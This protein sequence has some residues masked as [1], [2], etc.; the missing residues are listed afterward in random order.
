MTI[1]RRTSTWLRCAVACAV[2]AFAGAPSVFTQQAA[3]GA[4]PPAGLQNALVRGAQAMRSGDTATA[5]AAFREAVRLGPRFPDAHLDLGLVL[6]R[7]GR[8]EES[9][10]ELRRA[11]A[12]DPKLA[13]AH[14]FLGIFLYQANQAEPARRELQVELSLDPKSVEALTW[15]GTIDLAENHPERAVVSL[16]RA[17]EF[18]PDDLNI[19]ELRGRAHNQVAHDSYARM[20]RLAPNSWH[21][22]RVQAGLYSDEGRHTEA[23]AEYKAAIEAEGRNPDLYEGLGDEYR[24][25]SQLEDA[26]AAYAREVELS[27]NNPIALY[28]LG[29]TEIEQGQPE[30][31]VPRLQRMLQMAK[32]FPVAEYYLGR[33]LAAEGQD[34]EAVTWLTKAAA[35]A[36]EGEVAQRSWYELTRIYHRLHQDTAEQQALA[37]YK[38]L[39]DA[40]EQRSAKE[41]Q[42]WRKL[43]APEGPAQP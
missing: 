38:R 33:G 1:K 37:N 18:A 27:P 10:A 43:Q 15:L 8:M 14:L 25:L 2:L 3:R 28:N 36:R 20:A 22:H 19:L 5:E 13:S 7:E 9:I 23:V 11:V 30:A 40:A 42:D 4:A 31:G 6:G 24:K 41:V 21:V 32:G 35:D 12:L 34:A 39:R 29:S 26:R 17:A 16:D